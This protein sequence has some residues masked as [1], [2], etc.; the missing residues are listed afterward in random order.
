ML[1]TLITIPLS[2]GQSKHKNP[3]MYIQDDEIFLYTHGMYLAYP[4]KLY[5][6]KA[7]YKSKSRGYYTYKSKMKKIPLDDMQKYPW[8]MW[9]NAMRVD[10]DN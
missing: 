8:T 6:I 2:A 10:S 7:L 5:R 4:G 1:I 3:K 9:E